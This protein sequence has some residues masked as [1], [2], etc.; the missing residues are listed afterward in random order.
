VIV[1]F[2]IVV[3]VLF[4]HGIVPIPSSIRHR[5]DL[6]ALPVLLGLTALFPAI[7]G[8]LN[9]I[10]SQSEIHRLL[11][12][13]QSMVGELEAHIRVVDDV[14]ATIKSNNE[15][16]DFFHVL[17]LV[18]ELANVFTDEVAEWSLLYEKKVDEQ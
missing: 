11:V 1:S 18:D 8:T 16:S 13:S 6:Y 12:R 15:G 9:G 7:I 3:G 5:Y 10:H 2:D 17:K 14:E 4:G